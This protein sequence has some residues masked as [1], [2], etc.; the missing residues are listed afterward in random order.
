MKAADSQ[1]TGKLLPA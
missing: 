1:K